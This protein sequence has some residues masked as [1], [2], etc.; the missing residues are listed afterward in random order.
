MQEIRGDHSSPR[1]A[2]FEGDLEIMSP[3]R[4]HESIK[5]RIGRLIEAWCIETGVDITPY[6]SWTLEDEALD[7]GAEPDECYVLGDDEKPQRPDL[8]IEIVWTTG[9]IDKL[10]IYRALGVREVWYWRRGRLELYALRGER[11]EAI[12]HSEV[13]PGLDHA[14][15]LEFVAI[16]PM[17]KAVRAYRQALR[18]DTER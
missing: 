16:T 13:L 8:A 2:F 10:E 6:G 15:L 11:Y 7:R 4:E 14:Q 3:S 12:E 18:G 17:T 1:F 9:R 5:S